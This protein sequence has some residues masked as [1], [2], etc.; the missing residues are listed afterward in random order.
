MKKTFEAVE[1]SFPNHI[2]QNDVQ[3]ESR[4]VS[5][6]YGISLSIVGTMIGD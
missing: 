4:I 2:P 5:A 6:V 1:P 3:V